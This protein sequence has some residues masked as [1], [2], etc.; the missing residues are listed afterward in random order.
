M[1]SRLW[2][3]MAVGA[4]SVDRRLQATA[5]DFM[6]G[7]GRLTAYNMGRFAASDSGRQRSVTANLAEARI[8][9]FDRLDVLEP[10]RY[11]ESPP[12]PYL[13]GADRPGELSQ[14]EASGKARP[15]CSR[16]RGCGC[17]W[18]QRTAAQS[19]AVGGAG[20]GPLRCFGR[21]RGRW[22]RHRRGWLVV[23]LACCGQRRSR[24][25]R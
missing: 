2:A 17:G 1:R 5:V 22:R 24:R 21:R 4:A 19:G 13:E 23:L 3:R 7:R 25:P 9:R 18:S 16:N 8:A 15:A 20:Q 10:A 6:F 14:R 12:P 11:V